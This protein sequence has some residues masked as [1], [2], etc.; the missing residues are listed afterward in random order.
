MQLSTTFSKLFL[1][2]LLNNKL[3]HAPIHTSFDMWLLYSSVLEGIPDGLQ[4]A[5][6][7]NIAK[8]DQP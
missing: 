8:L 4:A 2:G 3:A 1:P 5:S 6:R 7:A